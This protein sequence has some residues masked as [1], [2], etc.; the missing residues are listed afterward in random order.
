[1]KQF[2]SLLFLLV[3]ANSFAQK[4]FTISGDVSKVKD[5]VAKV[6][7]NYYADGKSTMDSA[8]VKD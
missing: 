3:S 1:M 2:I 4:G 5:P 6:Y 7:L 8:E